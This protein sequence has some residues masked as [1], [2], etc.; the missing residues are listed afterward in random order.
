MKEHGQSDGV[1][2]HRVVAQEER[3]EGLARGQRVHG[4]E[5]LNHHE[6]GK[7]HGGGR[8]AHVVAEHLA[9]NFGELRG[10]L[11]VVGLNRTC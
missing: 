5:H 6:D 8:L 7:R 9:S 2:K 10:T 3:Q 1:D 4:I 11:V